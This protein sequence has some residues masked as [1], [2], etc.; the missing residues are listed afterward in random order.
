MI[1]SH[2]TAWLLALILFVI[3]L[4]LYKGGKEK[5]FKIVQMILRVFYLLIILTGGILLYQYYQLS[6]LYFVKAAVG[7][8]VIA[9]FEMILL[10]ISRQGRTTVLWYQFAVA[11]LLVFYLGFKLP[12]GIR[13][14]S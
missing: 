7:L 4:L 11:L 13:I 5:G 10:R 14:F 2:I 3:A 1:H 9:L 8:W 12:V 6:L